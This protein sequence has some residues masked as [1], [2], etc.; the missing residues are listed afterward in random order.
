MNCSSPIGR[1]FSNGSKAPSSDPALEPAPEFD[2]ELER[3]VDDV[4]SMYREHLRL[5][6]PPPTDIKSELIDS[7]TRFAFLKKILIRK[8]RDLH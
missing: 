1:V 8:K 7:L 5:L 4:D 6:H 2:P 3:I